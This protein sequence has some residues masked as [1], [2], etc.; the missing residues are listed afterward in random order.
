MQLNQQD[1]QNQQI[2]Q[3]AQQLQQGS[4][5]HFSPTTSSF[6]NTGTTVTYR[7]TS[8]SNV[9]AC[10]FNQSQSGQFLSSGQNQQQRFQEAFINPMGWNHL[11]LNYMGQNM[12]GLNGYRPMISAAGFNQQ[13][14]GNMM[15]AGQYM[16]QEINQLQQNIVAQPGIDIS[17]T[18]S[19]VI[20]S[21]FVPNLPINDMSLNVTEN[22][23]TISGTA[24][25][26]NQNLI[27]NRTV[28]L[29]TTVRA[30]SVDANLSSGILEIRLPK[31]ERVI[32]QRA[33]ASSSGAQSI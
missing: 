8:Q 18:S 25:T 14:S 10:G 31:I 30:E 32:A 21:A 20:V 26:G 9:N 7:M 16:P 27:L 19:D 33:V 4:Q 11:R 6:T 3:Q 22:S 24:W 17:E 5:V 23:V 1:L 15:V 28:A 29:P 2:G 12:S 13:G